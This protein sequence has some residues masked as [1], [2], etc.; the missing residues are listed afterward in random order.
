M[1]SASDDVSGRSA[2]TRR[3]RSFAIALVCIVVAAYGALVGVLYT[4]QR[5]MMFLPDPMFH[6]AADLN[7]PGYRD[8]VIQ[9]GDGERL[10]A[11]YRPADPGRAT[12]LYFHGNAGSMPQLSRR[13]RALA[14]EG[15]GVLVP[16]YRGYGGS[17][18][19][20]TEEGLAEDAR[21]AFDW[22]AKADPSATVVVYGESLGSGV[23][24]RLA[25]ERT[26]AAIVLDAPFTS[27]TDVAADRFPLIPVRWLL[28]DRFE[29]DARIAGLVRPV[30]IVHGD[31]DPIVPFRLGERLFALAREPKRFVRIP[32]GGHVDNMEAAWTDIRAFVDG[33][34]PSRP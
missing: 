2:R 22:L 21:A 16:A 10:V 31:A 4:L 12:I 29:S 23:S 7:L 5:Q 15:L 20:P 26:F 1:D 18:G 32:G 3:T 6:A 24:V 33:A 19:S 17:T 34:R 27:I 25:T 13:L 8:V 28:K 14:R 11:L 9:T 30:L